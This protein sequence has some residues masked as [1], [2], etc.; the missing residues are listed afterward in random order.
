[1][2]HMHIRTVVYEYSSDTC[3]RVPY[4]MN[5]GS[6]Y[7]AIK[8]LQEWVS[9]QSTLRTSTNSSTIMKLPPM[10]VEMQVI[11]SLLHR[12]KVYVT[13]ISTDHV[14]NSRRVQVYS[15]EENTWS[16]LPES[17][18]N[19]PIAIINDRITLIGGRDAQSNMLTN[20][21]PSWIE[22]EGE[23]KQI[24]PSLPTKRYS[25]R[26]CHRGNLLLV[27]GGAE[28]R[29]EEGEK[30][31]V[32]NKV[33]VYNFS[34]MKW[35]T[36]QSLQLPKPLRS[37]YL[38]QLDDYIY[39]MGGAH[40]FLDRV[41]AVPKEP[42]VIHN[43]HAWRARWSDVEEAAQQ[44]AAVP[45]SQHGASVWTPIT[46]PPILRPTIAMYN[47]AIISV[48]GILDGKSRKV[49]YK[50]V[51][52]ESD[53]PHWIEVGSMSVG[54]YRHAVVPLG[55]VGSALFVAGGFVWVPSDE[56]NVKSTSV[57]LVF[58]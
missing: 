5:A 30:G 31:E 50:L 6:L 52:Y 42:E 43:S 1:M 13:G 20:M 4:R 21:M 2:T 23:W 56:A 15:L 44:N 18:Y 8:L 35:T 29:T 58:L 9:P 25:T 3:A 45:P 26:V 57:E 55:N 27:A 7:V 51:G 48:G 36:P 19:A 47:N 37:H 39:L 32:T 46:A 22:E 12:N 28:A 17:N 38:I 16:T 24:L 53:S 40:T 34:T 10:P 49:I 54:R 14:P 33:H 41:D 11:T